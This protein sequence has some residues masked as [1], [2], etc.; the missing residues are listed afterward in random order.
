MNTLKTI[1]LA[2]SLVALATPSLAAPRTQARDHGQGQSLE[3]TC[4]EQVGKEAYEGEG[5]GHAGHL[6]AQR[7]SDCMMGAH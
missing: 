2:V 4:R 5:R 3:Q 1:V 7:F 6:Q